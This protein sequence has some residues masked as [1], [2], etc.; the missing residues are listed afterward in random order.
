VADGRRIL[1]HPGFHSKETFACIAR[2]WDDEELLILCPPRVT[3]FEFLKYLPEGPLT[4]LGDWTGRTPSQPARSTEVEFPE[5]PLL[6]VFTTGT[7]RGEPRLVLYSR[8]NILSSLDG[9]LSLFD[10]SRIK[11]IFCYPQPSHTFGLVLGY[12]LAH[13]RQ[14]PLVVGE[15]RYSS[16][17]HQLRVEANESGMLTL[18]TP[19]H[20]LDLLHYTTTKAIDLAPSYCAIV[21]GAPVQRSLWK[22][23]RERLHIERPSIGY[24][25]TEASPG[26]SHLPPGVEP[27]EDGEIGFPLSNVGVELVP[28]GVR[29]RGSSVALAVLADGGFTFPSEIV[30]SDKVVQREDRR[31]VFL[32]RLDLCLNRGGEKFSLEQIESAVN[33]TLGREVVCVAVSD[34]RLG[35]E[36]GLV[37]KG[38]PFSEDVAASLSSLF[39]WELGCAFE[40]RKIL[41]V[42][43][44]PQ[45]ANGKPDRKAAQKLLARTLFPVSVDEVRDFVPHRAPMI[46]IDEVLSAQR[47]GGE[48][49]FK[50]SSR[51]AYAGPNGLRRSSLVE[52]M[53]QS[54]AYVQACVRGQDEAPSRAFLAQMTS[55]EF[56]SDPSN[57]REG[58][59]L[60]IHVQCVREMGHLSLIEGAVRDAN[61]QFLAKANLKLYSE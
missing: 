23:L 28:E 30:L 19:T 2:A 36:L 46:W 10:Q 7:S 50:Y 39:T 31:M 13:I 5:R 38:E 55:V 41:F 52:L 60:T 11:S 14:I 53:A 34:S 33:R 29:F 21:G 51:G 47:M 57:L 4:W 43:E 49:R 17:F 12:L 35:E 15:G 56:L 20:F 37:V 44:L 59:E 1:L 45:N 3:Q 42:P 58:D 26:V 24:G 27:Q 40:T 48:C 54:Y 22:A 25:A 32:G 16:E 6:G 9:I 18:G 8:K 61:D